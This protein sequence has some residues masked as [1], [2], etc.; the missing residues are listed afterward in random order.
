MLGLDLNV[1]RKGGFR[2]DRDVTDVMI[3]MASG[4]TGGALLVLTFV[5]TPTLYFE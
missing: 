5:Q 4:G 3:I 2:S 1:A